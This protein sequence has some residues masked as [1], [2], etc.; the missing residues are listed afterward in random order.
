MSGDEQRL[1]RD[2]GGSKG[3]DCGVSAKIRRRTW[4]RARRPEEKQARREA[5]LAAARDLV[6]AGGLDA[7]SLSAIARRSKISKANLYRYFESREDIL[8][9]VI[10]EDSE[11]WSIE[12]AQT[13]G[14]L[15]GSDDHEAVIAGLVESVCARPRLGMLT[16]VMSSVLEHNV[17]AERI[18]EFKRGYGARV[19][20]L[21]AAL[22]AAL[23]LAP[24]DAMRFMTFFFVALAGAWPI[25]HP[26]AV[27]A[28]VLADEEFRPLAVDYETHLE[29]HARALLVGMLGSRDG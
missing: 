20:P 21:V 24:A 2:E 10:S 11:A 9:E 4:S 27:V 13:L 15:A 3:K 1:A 7:A 17:S 18:A 28:E 8:L 22:A 12:L 6:D 19:E 25:A 26:P 29:A 5:I 14:G 16:A 23:P